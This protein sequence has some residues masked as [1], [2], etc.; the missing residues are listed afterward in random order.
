MIPLTVSDVN[1]R[2][3]FFEMNLVSLIECIH[4]CS[5]CF[6]NYYDDDKV[7]KHLEY[8]LLI[9]LIMSNELDLKSF[10]SF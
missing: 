5:V 1:E 8:N 10:Q 7:D 3:S 2:E 6:M 4:E 9:E